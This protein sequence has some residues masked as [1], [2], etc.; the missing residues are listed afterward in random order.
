MQINMVNRNSILAK[1][2]AG[3]NFGEEVQR[4][5]SPQYSETIFIDLANGSA[6]GEGHDWANAVNDFNGHSSCHPRWTDT[7][8]E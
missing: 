6:G 1:C 5:A 2:S 3:V 8:K 7:I 4:W